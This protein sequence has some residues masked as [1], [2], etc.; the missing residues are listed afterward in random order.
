MDTRVDA[1]NSG[2]RSGGGCLDRI[3][4]R[5]NRTYWA[6]LADSSFLYWWICFDGNIFGR[7]W[8]SF[9]NV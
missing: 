9:I 6:S 1:D 5:K 4:I 3:G 2:F 8:S 7:N